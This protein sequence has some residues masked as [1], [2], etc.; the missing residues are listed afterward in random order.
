MLRLL[1]L[2]LL[3]MAAVT[4]GEEATAEGPVRAGD[5]L[6]LVVVTGDEGIHYEHGCAF[7]ELRSLLA[8]SEAQ[9]DA[10]LT[11]PGEPLLEVWLLGRSGTGVLQVG[12]RWVKTAAGVVPITADDHDRI[13][14]LV[15]NRIGQGVTGGKIKVSIEQAS[16]V[17][18]DPS[19]VEENR[20]RP[21]APL[22]GAPPDV[23]PGRERIG[24]IGQS[25][26]E[27]MCSS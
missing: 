7:Y 27:T 20:C 5:A 3:S 15:E 24:R 19:Y 14:Q 17:I 13:M 22:S 9:V 18:R 4:V 23:E 6:R 2:F 11:A 8:D 26:S 12:D 16:K 21:L 10:S 1:L 25:R